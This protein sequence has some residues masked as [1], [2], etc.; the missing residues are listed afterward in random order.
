MR[1]YYQIVLGK[2]DNLLDIHRYDARLYD[3]V[4]GRFLSADSIIPKWSDPQALDRYTYVRNNPLKYTDPDGHIF[5]DVVDIVSFGYS[6]YTFA[7]VPSWANAGWLAG[8]T[9]GLLPGIPGAGTIKAGLKGVDAIAGVVKGW[10]VFVKEGAEKLARKEVKVASK[11]TSRAARREA[12]RKNNTPTSRSATSQNGSGNNRQYVTEGPD[13]K[14]RVQTHHTADKD[15][16]QNH[17]HDSKPKTDPLT[18]KPIKNKHGQ[19]KY[20][21]DGS[22]SVPYGD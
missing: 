10:S 4:L 12:M 6:A 5:W 7:T 18:N 8:D 9:I 3:P 15:H 17:W 14:P 2:G 11:K 22:S 13:G 16:P 19:Y 20:S 1:Q 21:K